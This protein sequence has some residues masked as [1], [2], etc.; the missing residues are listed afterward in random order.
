MKPILLI[1]LSTIF[2]AGCTANQ[3]RQSYEE[4]L[5]YIEQGDAPQALAC[6]KE[7]AELTTLPCHL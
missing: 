6:L 2:L 3:G 1:L 5:R 7:A 4:A